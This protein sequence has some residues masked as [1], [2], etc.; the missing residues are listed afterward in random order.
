MSAWRVAPCLLVLRDEFNELSPDRDKGAD[1]TIGDT[2]HQNETSDHN[3][4]ENG[5]VKADDVDSSGPWPGTNFHTLVMFIV[6]RCRSGV[7]KRIR[8]IIHDHVIYHERDGFKGTAYTG[9][10]PHVNHAHFSCNYDPSIFS[11]TQPWQIE[12]EFGMAITSDDIAAIANA[13]WDHQEKNAYS[14]TPQRT[15][16][17]LSFVPSKQPHLDTQAKV[18]AVM[19]TL[20]GFIASETADNATQDRALS[21]MHDAIAALQ[22]TIVAA[23]LAGLP[24]MGTSITQEQANQAFLYAMRTQFGASLPVSGH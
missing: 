18:D 24:E 6:N 22:P 1:G 9:S 10:D 12:A 20:N 4:D 2:A 19:A 3:P 21:A 13:V 8:Y 17:M 14:G 23:V 16:T 11:Q 15:G 7:E 5:W